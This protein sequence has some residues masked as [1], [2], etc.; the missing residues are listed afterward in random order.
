MICWWLRKCHQHMPYAWELAASVRPAASPC[1]T[2][3]ASRVSG[4]VSTS[5]EEHRHFQVAGAISIGGD[6]S[7]SQESL[8]GSR[9][10]TLLDILTGPKPRQS[11]NATAVTDLDLEPK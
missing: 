7:S 1:I 10:P 2:S 4:V 8:N 3:R 11:S 9:E 6:K 5:G